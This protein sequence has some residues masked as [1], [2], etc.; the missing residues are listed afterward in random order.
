MTDVTRT[1]AADDEVRAPASPATMVPLFL[2]HDPTHEL[3]IV[4]EDERGRTVARFMR[5]GD[6]AI[7]L[8]RDVD[9]ST[10]PIR[11]LQLLAADADQ[12]TIPE[13]PKVA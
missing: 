6:A 1:I 4:V 12:L 8:C 10:L 2:R 7:F 5:P 11:F 13:R 9:R 3:S